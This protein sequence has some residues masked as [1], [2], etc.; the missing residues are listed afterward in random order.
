MVRII[1][2][3][4][5]FLDIRHQQRHFSEKRLDPTDLTG[6]IS[7]PPFTTHSRFRLLLVDRCTLDSKADS[8]PINP[9]LK[10][11]LPCHT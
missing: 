11:T 2:Y 3:S 5:E 10:K 8:A 9:R 7:R 4:V 1:A 6:Q